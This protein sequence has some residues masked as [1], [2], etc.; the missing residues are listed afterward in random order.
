MSD[1]LT[2]LI[3]MQEKMIT[4]DNELTEMK[5]KYIKDIDALIKA[6]DDLIKANGSK[7]LIETNKLHIEIKK[8]HIKANDDLAKF[9]RKLIENNI[10]LRNKIINRPN[11]R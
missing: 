2:K 3:E 5:E 6:N 8:K 1:E 10:I 4:A 7:I 11:R 9:I